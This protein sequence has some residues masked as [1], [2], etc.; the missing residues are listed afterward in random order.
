[1]HEMKC[2]EL[3]NVNPH[4]VSREPSKVILHDV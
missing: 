3:R 1:M 2:I 4:L